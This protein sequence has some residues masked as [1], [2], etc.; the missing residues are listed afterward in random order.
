MSGPL[1]VVENPRFCSPDP[2]RDFENLGLSGEGLTF[3]SIITSLKYHVFKK[4]YG[5]W[6][7]CSKRANAPF[8]IIFSK[9]SKHNLNF[10]C[11]FFYVVLK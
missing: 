1:G 4:K 6:S 5:K 8:S 3:Y 7:I 10:S 9:Y 2:H 11:F